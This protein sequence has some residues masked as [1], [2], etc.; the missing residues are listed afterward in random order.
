MIQKGIKKM[1]TTE[2]LMTEK[3]AKRC[4]RNQRVRERVKE[5]RGLYPDASE[6]R[7]FACVANEVRVSAQTI[8]NIMA[9]GNN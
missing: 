8:R 7:I 4:A 1:I 3:E 9:H 2:A 5:L 6:N